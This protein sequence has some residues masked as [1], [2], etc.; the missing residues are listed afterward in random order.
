M[1]NTVKA[2]VVEG[3]PLIREGD[4][5]ASIISSRFELEDKDIVV[6][7][8]TIV[9][10]AEGR[11]RDLD[12]YK[13]SNKAINIAEKLGKD[14]RIVQ[15]VLEESDEVLIDHPILLVRAKFGNICINAGIDASNV[16][17]G[18]IL[19][20]PKNPQKSA[21][22]IKN[23]IEEITRK[24]VGVI[25]TDTNGRCFRKGV[26]GFAIGVAGVKA[27]RDWV[28]KKDLYGNVL[29]VTVECVA[30][31]I[32]AFANLLMGEG[33]DGTPVVIIRGLDLV[34]EGSINEVYRSEKEDIIRKAI[35][36]SK[37]WR[38]S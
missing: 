16:E 12:F 19:L 26:V 17:S 15:A 30:D 24:K 10:K 25:I 36:E 22:E 32:A 37:T 5:L 23:R 33:S 27:M 1:I 35:R 7:C 9:S 4:D 2:F 8:S 13:P 11:V 31:E 21:E 38:K 14:A 34:G 20:P 28:G 29:E 6:L 3:I 18:K